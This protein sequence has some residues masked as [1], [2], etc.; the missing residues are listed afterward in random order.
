M[1][2]I[3]SAPEKIDKGE[4]VIEES[5]TKREIDLTQDWDVCFLPGQKVDMS[6]IFK[7]IGMPESSCPSCKTIYQSSKYDSLE[8]E[9]DCGMTF[10]IITTDSEG[11]TGRSELDKL[12]NFPVL[13]IESPQVD[14]K[15]LERK[16]IEDICD[17]IRF[18]RRVRLLESP[19]VG[20]HG[21][22]RDTLLR[23]VL[24]DDLCDLI[25]KT[26][27]SINACKTRYSSDISLGLETTSLEL[28]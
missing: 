3:R 10:R 9:C 11:T 2:K 5:H 15:I 4:F 14:R 25:K 19:L 20:W 8:I 6:M 27:V 23:E 16:S 24:H 26:E 28:F 7:R 13:D 21:Q 18:F 22:G 1:P 12:E 17:D